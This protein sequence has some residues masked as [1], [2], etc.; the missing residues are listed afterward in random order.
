[1]VPNAEFVEKMNATDLKMG[2]LDMK[3]EDMQADEQQ[4]TDDVENK[5][6]SIID[7][8][9]SEKE[10]SEEPRSNESVGVSDEIGE[11]NQKWLRENSDNDLEEA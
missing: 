5:M 6:G 2:M 1:M 4:I 7:E 3:G 9:D 8:Q 11:E 10:C